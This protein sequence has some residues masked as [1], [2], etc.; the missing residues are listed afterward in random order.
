MFK[1][2]KF[3]TVFYLS[4]LS[5]QANHVNKMEDV[6]LIVAGIV[7]LFLLLCLTIGSLLYVSGVLHTIDVG[8]GSP[9]IGQALVAYKF[10]KGPYKNAGKLFTE[11]CC[12]APD[13]KCLGIYYD[14]PNEVIRLIN[15]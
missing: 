3:G 15:I 4:A 5:N 7:F 10:E 14:N 1:S 6:T 9:P 12:A 11:V 8:A 13:Y 2:V